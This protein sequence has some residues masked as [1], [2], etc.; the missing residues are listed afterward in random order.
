M[1]EFWTLLFRYFFRLMVQEHET[2]E[3]EKRR[4]LLE[5][6]LAAERE[7]V[8][9]ARRHDLYHHIRLLTDYLKRGDVEGQRPI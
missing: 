6:R 4:K 5:N 3:A 7:V 1:S 2:Q 8:A 9:K